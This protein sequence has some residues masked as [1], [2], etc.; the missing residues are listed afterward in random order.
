MTSFCCLDQKK[1]GVIPGSPSSLILVLLISKSVRL[2]LSKITG[3]HLHLLYYFHPGSAHRPLFPGLLW[4]FLSG[5]PAS[6]MD[7]NNSFS[8]QHLTRSFKNGNL[9]MLKNPLVCFTQETPGSYKALVM[10]APR[11]LLDAHFLFFPFLSLLQ[12]HLPSCWSSALPGTLDL[13]LPLVMLSSRHP[14]VCL[15]HLLPVFV[16]MLTFQLVL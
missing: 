4:Q 8:T 7:Q 12:P 11:Y 9:V 1:F 5:L 2:C 6:P 3:K 13:V 15:L 10:L 16:Q 14:Q